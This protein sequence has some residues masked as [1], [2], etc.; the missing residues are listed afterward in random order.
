VL[1]E[2]RPVDVGWNG[3]GNVKRGHFVGARVRLYSSHFY[4]EQV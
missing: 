1:D 4:L 3:P 2:E